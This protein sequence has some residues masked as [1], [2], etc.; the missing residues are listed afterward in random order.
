MSITP[1]SDPGAA[2]PPQA[3]EAAASARAD[4]AVEFTR[5]RKT[6][7]GR[8]AV[9]DISF[10]IRPGEFFSL[11][12]PSGCGKSTT[13]RMIAGF[14]QPDTEG[15]GEVRLNGKL[16]NHLRP[17]ER[18]LG[19]V[20]QSYALFPHLT[21]ARNIAFGLEQR[22]VGK[23][24]IAT[25]VR[26]AMDLVQLDAKTF[27]ERLP[28]A[29]SGGQRQ[30]VALAR[31]LVV[32][33][34][35]LL[36]DEP[37]GALDLKLRKEMQQELKDLNTRL[38]ITFV[39]VTHD[40]E[41]ALTMSDRIAVM[42]DA[43]IAQV[44]TPAEIYERPRTPFVARFIGES[45]FL[46]GLIESNEGGRLSVCHPAGMFTALAGTGSAT[47]GTRVHLALRPERLHID[48]EG[49][50]ALPARIAHVIYRGEMLHVRL[51]TAGGGELTVATR[52]EGQLRRPV[53]WNPG[54]TVRVTWF[55]EDMQ[56]LEE[57]PA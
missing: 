9:R 12:G 14:E 17:Y 51:T 45:N 50:N 15:G 48:G 4:Y 27:G 28:P 29:L 42:A 33:P 11:L 35:I 46:E 44:G 3:S 26:G 2:S 40:Q 36:L 13:L 7:G 19:M 22:G 20:F 5:V 34:P 21:V 56:R 8:A 30:R 47:V 57:D 25:R 38:G 6:Y 16:V 49:D 18:D 1:L 24:D 41:E 37:L 55:A 32:E 43:R 23:A 54:D 52:N 10:S 31:A 53:A 39:Y